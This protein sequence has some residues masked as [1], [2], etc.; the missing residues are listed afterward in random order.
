MM[1]HVNMWVIFFNLIDLCAD[2][3][4]NDCWMDDLAV[5]VDLDIGYECSCHGGLKYPTEWNSDT[6][7]CQFTNGGKEGLL[8]LMELCQVCVC[9]CVCVRK[10]ERETERERERNGMGIPACQ[11]KFEVIYPHLLDC[12]G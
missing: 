2:N 12:G 9:V 11:S 10:G 8:I 5:C 6:K 7:Q 3:L 4:L 1:K